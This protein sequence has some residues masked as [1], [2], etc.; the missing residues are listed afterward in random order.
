MKYAGTQEFAPGTGALVTSKINYMKNKYLALL[1]L[2]FA[3]AN[4]SYGQDLKF[5]P[6]GDP[7]KWTLEITPFFVLP[8]VSG[9]VQSEMLSKEFGI[10]PAGFISSLH[11]TVMMDMS[12][13]KVMFF[14]SAGYLFNYN[15]IEK[16]LWMSESGNQTI[17]A[18]PALQ[19]HIL[20][21]ITG[22]RFRLGKKFILD[23][24]A[25][26]RYTY[27]RLFGDVE[28]IQNTNEIDENAGF[29]DPILGIRAHYY[30][31]PRV[32][33]ELKADCGG[34]GAGSK[35]TWSVWFNSGYAV[36]P[37][38]DL[39]AG[40]ACLSNKY[41]SETGLGRTYGMTSVTYGFDLGARFY[42]SK[43]AKDPAVFKKANKD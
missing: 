36:S 7:K 29:L 27:Y 42:I 43:R 13:S 24:Y 23:P 16:I 19:K 38:V 25:G 22:M 35:F 17:T 2:L 32:P 8:W 37:S 41:E 5:D 10:D 6:K 12:V 34:F 40:I 26:I 31:H 30:P 21:V 3:L 1:F 11:G 20:E 18:Q 33:I 14:A 9:E 39:I 28:G 15:Q 4:R